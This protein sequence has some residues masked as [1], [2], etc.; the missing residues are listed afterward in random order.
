MC[1]AITFVL[2][3][4]AP[5]AAAAAAAVAASYS[6]RSLAPYLSLHRHGEG[7]RAIFTGQVHVSEG[8]GDREGEREQT[9][10]T[11]TTTARIV[12]KTG[13]QQENWCKKKLCWKDGSSDFWQTACSQGTWATVASE[14]GKG[15]D[16]RRPACCQQRRRAK[17]DAITN[18]IS[19]SSHSSS[20]SF[21]HSCQ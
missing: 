14:T 21:S 18:V 4:L 11:M 20:R 8:K 5:V 13:R 9:T 17:T 10:T 1:K 16:T 7:Q 3:T 19:V 2:L 12:R 6:L 15:K